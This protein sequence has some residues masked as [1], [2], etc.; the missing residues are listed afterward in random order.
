MGRRGRDGKG[1]RRLSLFFFSFPSPLALLSLLSPQ[2]LLVSQERRLSTLVRVS[3][4][5]VSMELTGWLARKT[6]QTDSRKN[7]REK[8][9][10]F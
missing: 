4:S 6:G 8:I 2:A 7:F 3:Y 5:R 1:R 9:G 10:K